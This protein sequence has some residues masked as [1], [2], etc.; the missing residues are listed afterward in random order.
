VEA[1][2]LDQSGTT[3]IAAGLRSG[4]GG[5]DVPGFV[6]MYR[7]HAPQQTP[8][9]SPRYESLKGGSAFFNVVTET[10]FDGQLRVVVEK[11]H[12]K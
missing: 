4:G 10:I 11:I 3:T 12:L 1:R 8:P 6:R 7:T 5:S 2:Y 9:R